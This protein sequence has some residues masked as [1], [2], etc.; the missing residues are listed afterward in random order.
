MFPNL[1]TRRNTHNQQINC[2]IYWCIFFSQDYFVLCSRC[3]SYFQRISFITLIYHTIILCNLTM[4]YYF[5]P[6]YRLK[7]KRNI[8]TLIFFFNF[9]WTDT[10]LYSS[11]QSESS[12][13]HCTDLYT[14]QLLISCTE[15]RMIPI[16][17]RGAITLWNSVLR[18]SSCLTNSDIL[19]SVPKIQ[20]YN[21]LLRQFGSLLWIPVIS[22]L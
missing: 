19:I 4:S 22:G 20:L 8:F 16:L 17:G 11:S 18:H 9:S 3:A 7:T 10:L 12:H 15:Y 5:N 1:S 2:F 14:L 21:F 13:T 6:G